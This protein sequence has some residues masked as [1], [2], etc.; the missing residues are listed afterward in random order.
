MSKPP[1]PQ[2]VSRLLAKAGFEKAET[3]RG[4]TS[5]GFHVI[6]YRLQAGVVIVNWWADSSSAEFDRAQHDAMLS[7]Y[8]DT[9][10]EA[11]YSA[12]I[13][14]DQIGRPDHV[15]VTVRKESQ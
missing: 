12:F 9:L 1:T 7:S 4:I 3:H 15:I 8:A 10:T 5:E 6:R 14:N 11:G 13:R 2:T